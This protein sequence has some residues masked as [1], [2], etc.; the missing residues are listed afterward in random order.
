MN[1]PW[2]PARAPLRGF[3]LVELLVVLAVIGVLV[4]LLLPAV[5]NA[6]E[7]ARRAQC[8]NNL[9]QLALGLCVCEQQGGAFP[10]GCLGSVRS[11]DKRLIAW[12]VP[13][14]AAIE[15]GPL[16]DRF[17]FE[18]PS[19]DAHNLPVARTLIPQYLCPSQADG[20]QHSESAPWKQAA[21]TDYS[22]LYGV[23]GAGRNATDLPTDPATAWKQQTLNPQSLGV[24][25]YET[26]TRPR[27]VTDGLSKTACVGEAGLRRQQQMEW[28]NGMNLFAQ[29]QSNPIGGVGLGNEL[30]SPHTS[31]AG[32]AFCDGHVSF[33][34]DDVEQTVLTA[35]LTRA[36]HE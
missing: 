3:T 10:V 25:L 23:E 16:L 9:K 24:M 2:A 12:S 29:E 35:M 28:V 34:S 27:E 31:G 5:Q 4:G 21:F 22:G 17:D 18:L 14:L 7:S 30:G 8:Q 19:Y 20:P 11:P 36:G 32:L 15:Q 26:A 6:R 1:A 33:V 13:L